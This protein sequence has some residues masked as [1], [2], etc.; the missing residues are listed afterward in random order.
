MKNQLKPVVYIVGPTASGKTAL[1]VEIAKQFHGE[2]ICADSMQIY[3]NMPIATA[4]PTAAEKQ[5]VPHH[6]FEFLDPAEPFNVS[7]YCKLAKKTIAEVTARG[8]LPIL[9]GGT[10]LYIDAVFDNID[11]GNSAENENIRRRLTEFSDQQGTEPLYQRLKQIDPVAAEKININD[12]KRIIRA[13]EVFSVSGEKI[14]DR[15][16]RSKQSGPLYHNLMIGT[17]YRD[18]QR[19]YDRIEKRVDLMLQNGLLAEAKAAYNA[20]YAATSAQA[21][22]HKELFS[23]FSG[24]KTE[25]EAIEHLKQQTRRYAKRQMTW[26]SHKEHLKPIYM[27][28]AANPVLTAAEYINE[29]LKEGQGN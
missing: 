20:P 11:F 9:V 3:R 21:I 16:A 22:G 23:V 28:E 15:V 19:L 8:H 14:S 12:R 29:F 7:E 1:S 10:G 2:I 26:F 18:R 6:L 25:A 13:L 27:D 4:A 17:F 5:G 24:E